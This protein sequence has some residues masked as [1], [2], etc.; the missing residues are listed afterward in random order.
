MEPLNKAERR[1]AINRFIGFYAF[2]LMAVI[3]AVY[4]LFNTPAGIFKNKIREYKGSEAEELQ[5]LT[6]IEGMN[7]NLKN[8]IHADEQYL[9]SNN[10]YEKGALLGNLQEYQKNINDALVNLK[11]DSVLFASTVSK[12]ESY[13]YISAFNAVVAY[14][15]TITSLQKSLEGKG[16]DA[17]EL[18]KVKSQLDLCNQQLDICK[19]L[20]AKPAAAAPASGGGG[21]GAK[22]AELQKTLEKCQADL[23]ACQTA[24]SGTVLP[25]PVVSSVGNS[26]TNRSQIIFDASQDLYTMAE[27]TKNLIERRGILSAARQLLQKAAPAYPD[28]DRLNKSINQI[29][30]ELKKLSNMG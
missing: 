21:G 13:N 24:K 20:A 23:A 27:K 15:N 11:N 10:E 25:P 28:K 9:S 1:T 29:E 8:I 7:A 14:R 22:E 26:E 6:K 12:R 16:G 3:L 4:F 30:T 5:L 2:S 19:L 17:S 18:L